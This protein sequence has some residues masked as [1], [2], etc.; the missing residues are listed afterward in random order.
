MYAV[1]PAWGMRR[2]GR[3]TAKVGD[4]ERI[5]TALKEKAPALEQLWPLRITALSEEAQ[6]P[7]SAN[8][9]TVIMTHKDPAAGRAGHDCGVCSAS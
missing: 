6:P 5:T 8:G 9:N 4:F 2:M 3:Q 7:A 1:L